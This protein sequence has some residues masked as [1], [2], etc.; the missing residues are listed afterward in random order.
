MIAAAVRDSLDPLCRGVACTQEAV[1]LQDGWENRRVTCRIEDG[2]RLRV[3]AWSVSTT[4]YLLPMPRSPNRRSDKDRHE[5]IHR[6]RSDGSKE[7]PEE[8]LSRGADKMRAML[9]V[10]LL[11][12]AVQ[13]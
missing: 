12:H 5:A 10:E 4:M 2:G 8:A 13:P 1:P 7:T 3:G 11:C 6:T 9:E